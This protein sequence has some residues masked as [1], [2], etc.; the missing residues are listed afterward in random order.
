MSHDIHTHIISLI[1]YVTFFWFLWKKNQISI[2]LFKEDT[3]ILFFKTML[4]PKTIF[5]RNLDFCNIVKLTTKGMYF[6]HAIYTSHKIGLK[7]GL[8]LCHQQFRAYI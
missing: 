2:L 7:T 4:K 6:R 3:F 8:I 5:L 1:R